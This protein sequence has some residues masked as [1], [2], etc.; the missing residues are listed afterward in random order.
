M[1]SASSASFCFNSDS[2]LDFWNSHPL[3]L[4]GIRTE[5]KS[6]ALWSCQAVRL[7]FET[8]YKTGENFAVCVKTIE[9]PP[10]GIISDV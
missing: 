3:Q 10:S 2:K 7:Y 5:T 6:K 4:Q 1:V 9:G 8:S